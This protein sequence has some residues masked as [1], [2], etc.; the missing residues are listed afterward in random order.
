VVFDRAYE[1]L[2]HDPSL[3]ALDSPFLWDDEGVAYEVGTLSK[4]LAPA[5]RVGY[6]IGPDGALMEALVQRTSDSGF[7]APLVTQEIA[8]YMLD[9]H[10]AEQIRGVNAGYR[11]KARVVRDRIQKELLQYLEGY[12]GGSAGFY[13]YLTFRDIL[14]T[15]GSDFFRFLTRTTG[16]PGIDGPAHDRNPRVIYVPGEFCVHPEGD[17]VFRGR[18]QLR[19]SYGFEPVDR[20]EAAVGTMREAAEYAAE[21]GHRGRA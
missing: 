18:R 6:L 10:V 15:E 7:S 5:L 16:D 20:I 2:I 14:T 11:E 17:L 4:V 9:H 12:T 8:S 21:R 13:F 19:I 1:D 3:G